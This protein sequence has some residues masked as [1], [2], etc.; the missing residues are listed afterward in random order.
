MPPRILQSI[1]LVE[2]GR[3]D[4]GT[5][6]VVPWP[7]AINAGG[8]GRYYASKEEAI[9]AVRQ[10]QAGGLRSIDVGCAQVN[11]MHHPHAFA[12][13]DAAFEPAANAA[14][15]ARFLRLLHGATGNWPLAVAAYH[16][17]TPELGYAYARRVLA[18]WPGAA[19]YGDLPLLAGP[20]VPKE[21][22]DLAVYTPEFVAQLRRNAQALRR[23]P[24]S[25]R[26]AGLAGQGPDL[27]WINRPPRPVLLNEPRSS[28][29]RRGGARPGR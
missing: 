22:P 8:T 9:G 7:W 29:A 4:P 27:V 24:G 11:L 18:I 16:S 26:V 3:V 5:G 17:Q 23:V 21:I 13:L 6:R 14:Y 15:A 28:S 19:R 1:G 20:I 2:S 25:R 10:F 12:S